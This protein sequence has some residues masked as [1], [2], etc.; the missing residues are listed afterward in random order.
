VVY[1][2]LFWG[3]TLAKPAKYAILGNIKTLLPKHYTT[4]KTVLFWALNLFFGIEAL[5]FK[6]R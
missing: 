6:I 4:A 1:F 3:V 2:R 5:R